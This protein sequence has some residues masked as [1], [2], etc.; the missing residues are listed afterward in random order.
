MLKKLSVENFKKLNFEIE[1]DEVVAFVGPNNSGKSSALQ[2]IALWY[3]ALQK[4]IEKRETKQSKAKQRTG[5]AIN[6]KDLINLPVPSTKLLWKNLQVQKKKDDGNGQDKVFI[7]IKCEGELFNKT[8][9]LGFEFYYANEESLYA[10]LIETDSE[11]IELDLLKNYRVGFLPPM[12][13]L[14]TEEDK[15]EAGSIQVRIGEGR[16]A[17]VLR[18]LCYLV[19]KRNTEK[20]KVIVELLN[21]MFGVHLNEPKY[22]EQTGKLELTYK[23][24]DIVYDIV[25][26]GKG[27]QQILLILSYLSAEE[28]RILLIDEPDAHLETI[29]QREVYKLL[30]NLVRDNKGQLIIATHSEV[31]L[32]EAA[33][34]DLI[35]AFIGT[36]H[37]VNNKSHLV[38]SLNTIGFDQYLLAEQ[39]K[40][41]LYLEGATDLDILKEFAR[42][43]KHPVE[44]YL[45]FAFVK[46]V[47][48]I[49]S[50]AKEHFY[51]IQR[52]ALKE[53]KGVAIFDRLNT[54][55]ESS[56]QLRITMWNRNEIENYIPIPESIYKFAE[57]ELGE[58]IFLSN[59]IPELKKIIE[60]LI[61]PIALENKEDIF[62]IDTKVS[63]LLERIF[64]EFYKQTNIRLL[65]KGEFYRLISFVS[66][67]VINLEVKEKLDLILE[68]ASRAED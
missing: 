37:I 7:K 11:K 28:N 6:R 9:S 12:S 64:D 10:R 48:N 8:W 47:A 35:V 68:V 22:Y 38:K 61:P 27:F 50:D 53:F 57:A 24:N 16:T 19:Y 29:R 15:L 55:P 41:I 44:K 3:L 33:E 49:P 58:D 2:A 45:E 46:Y 65:R 42:K 54:K 21:K 59:K 66:P 26:S 18:N 23:E 1:L 39:K 4:W 13:G 51:A 30:T 31:V 43:L 60:R 36:P 63:S 40:W 62:W 20:W 25:N 56:E 67:E 5:V 34:K 32:N 52:E 14:A 17:E